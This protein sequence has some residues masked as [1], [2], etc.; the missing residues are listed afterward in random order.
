MNRNE[1][2]FLENLTV[3]AEVNKQPNDNESPDGKTMS[4]LNEFSQSPSRGFEEEEEKK[5]FDITLM[6]KESDNE[7]TEDEHENSEKHIIENGHANNALAN[8]AAYNENEKSEFAVLLTDFKNEFSD[9]EYS[10]LEHVISEGST[11]PHHVKTL[12]SSALET[13][14]IMKDKEDAV[15]TFKM[16]LQTMQ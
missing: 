4:P 1:G 7:G 11:V 2:D 15:D 6:D 8:N 3:V 13:Y 5:L 16:Y 10:K 14:K 12:V 9:E